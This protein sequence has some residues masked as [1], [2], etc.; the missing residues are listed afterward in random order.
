MK[1]P[2]LTE[3]GYWLLPESL[4][5]DEKSATHAAFASALLI[6]ASMLTIFVG[7]YMWAGAVESTIMLSISSIFAFSA[8]IYLRV[9]GSIEVSCNLAVFG[10]LFALV[11]NS[12]YTGGINSPS[13]IWIPTVLITVGFFLP[14]RSVWLWTTL[15]GLSTLGV[16]YAEFF[17][18]KIQQT[19]PTEVF[20]SVRN[21]SAI[22]SLLLAVSLAWGFKKS[23]EANTQLLKEKDLQ[24]QETM[25]QMRVIADSLE[26]Q[27]EQNKSLIRVLSHDVAN[28]V[29][30][31]D[32]WNERS[33][34]NPAKPKITRAVKAIGEVLSLVRDFQAV[35]D[36]KKVIEKNPF[37]L[38]LSLQDSL[39]LL[40]DRIKAKSMTVNVTHTG[41]S[42]F[43]EGD[44][45]IVQSQII[46][47]LITNA[48][49]FSPNNS[50][51]EISVTD[52]ARHVE[53]KI[54]DH[55][56]GIPHDI[57]DNI[58]KIDKKT[59]RLGING[60]KGTGF[61]MPLVLSYVKMHGGEIVINSW[62]SEESPQNQG[63][64]VTVS[65]PKSAFEAVA[66]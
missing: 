21:F 25:S 63:T 46:S 6:G 33:P 16:I 51:I 22:S 8:L 1:I 13:L 5:T 35:M 15:Y 38:Y 39:A 24:L 34:D 49:K 7:I 36:G 50:S 30:V 60:E 58:F 45:R 20:T 32:L 57:L 4:S 28:P 37:D 65:F 42:S 10:L 54:R 3:I 29:Q 18:I 43:I 56:I 27:L 44:R 12:I 41:L 23:T 17:G 40:E 31:I 53:L 11:F 19:I 48:I 26:G 62:T 2:S 66:S 47:N 52:R 64:L 59:S 55:G 9:K 61:G 14:D